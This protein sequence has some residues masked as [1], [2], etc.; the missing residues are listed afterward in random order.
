MKDSIMPRVDQK[1]G[2]T[3][4]ILDH[5]CPDHYGLSGVGLNRVAKVQQLFHSELLGV[6]YV[7]NQPQSLPKHTD[8]FML[9]SYYLIETGFISH[10][11]PLLL[12][13]S[14]LIY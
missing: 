11:P 1:L 5:F 14:E 10:F 3:T 6:L 2:W 13:Y 9:C 4:R 7:L 8:K 12:L